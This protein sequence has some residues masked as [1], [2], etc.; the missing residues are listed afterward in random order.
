LNLPDYSGGFIDFHNSSQ[1]LN[2]VNTAV[3]NGALN[4]LKPGNCNG[5]SPSL[6]YNGSNSD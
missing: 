6:L 3:T 4:G 2:I 1:L 5:I